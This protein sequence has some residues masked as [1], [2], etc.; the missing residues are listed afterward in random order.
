MNDLPVK[1]VES[2]SR[3]PPEHLN[4]KENITSKP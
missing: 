4:L 3:H 2:S 1:P